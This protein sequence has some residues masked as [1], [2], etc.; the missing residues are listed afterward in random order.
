[1]RTRRFDSRGGVPV[2]SCAGLSR[3]WNHAHAVISTL[4]IWLFQTIVMLLL[5]KSNSEPKSTAFKL[6]PAA[7]QIQTFE[8]EVDQA[9][10]VAA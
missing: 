5:R 3:V 9:D 4:A 7:G 6:L 1:M 2:I 10:V 8:P